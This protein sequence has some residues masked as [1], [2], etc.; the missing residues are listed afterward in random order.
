MPISQNIFN[1][2][3]ALQPLDPRAQVRLRNIIRSLPEPDQNALNNAFGHFQWHFES[4][5][6]SRWLDMNN[7]AEQLDNVFMLAN[8]ALRDPMNAN[9]RAEKI[10]EI[11][12]FIE[13]RYYAEHLNVLVD[14]AAE[15]IPIEYGCYYRRRFLE[16]IDAVTSVRARQEFKL[17]AYGG[18]LCGF[19]SGGSSSS[20]SS[21]SNLRPAR[22]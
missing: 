9:A 19:F 13:K 14:P 15:A 12:H 10:K 21:S 18:D 16:G 20:S 5:R 8:P 1:L 22:L 6:R 11:L 3:I 4:Y 17:G 7:I 2:L